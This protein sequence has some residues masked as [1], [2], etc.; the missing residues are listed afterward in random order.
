MDEI[1]S[2]F[3]RAET[4]R[5]EVLMTDAEQPSATARMGLLIQRAGMLG[6]FGAHRAKGGTVPAPA[7]DDFAPNR[8]FKSLQ[9]EA[10]QRGPIAQAAAETFNHGNHVKVL[11]E[12][13]TWAAEGRLAAVAKAREA[14]N[15]SLDDL[16]E[17]AGLPRLYSPPL[18]GGGPYRSASGAGHPIPPGKWIYCPNTQAR[19]YGL[20]NIA[21]CMHGELARFAGLA[22]ESILQPDEAW[23]ED[24]VATEAD[25]SIEDTALRTY[26]ARWE[27]DGG[28]TVRMGAVFRYRPEYDAWEGVGAE[29]YESDEAMNLAR[30]GNLV[31]RRPA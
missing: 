13:K 7:T 3:K 14:L 20:E 18:P 21:A 26:V 6:V 11:S 27:L 2:L 25:G 12:T 23:R 1:R 9:G 16:R 22:G 28:E 15:H 17:I 10:T 19:L 30:K 29:L 5:R 31:W 8:A 4:L 24:V